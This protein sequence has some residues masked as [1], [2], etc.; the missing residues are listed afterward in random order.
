M[1]TICEQ[2]TH[3]MRTIY[4]QCKLSTLTRINIHKSTQNLL[5]VGEG[6]GSGVGMAV[7]FG[8]GTDEGTG[9]DSG[10]GLGVGKGVGFSVTIGVGLV[11]GLPNHTQEYNNFIPGI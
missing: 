8:V 10:V 6:V 9:D 1:Q 4:T 2:Y 11:V 5:G 7:K 3:N